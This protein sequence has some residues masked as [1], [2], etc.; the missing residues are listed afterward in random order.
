[1]AS[2]ATA[3]VRGGFKDL[4]DSFLSLIEAAG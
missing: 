1:V 4:E 3:E 2:G